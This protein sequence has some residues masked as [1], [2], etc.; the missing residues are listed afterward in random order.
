MTSP[1]PSPPLSLLTLPIEIQA[2][3]LTNRHFYALIP[4]PTHAELLSTET[5]ANRLLACVG[6][7]R[8]RPVAAFSPKMTM[9]KKAP[10]GAHAHNRFC[11]ECGRR[12]VP[13]P[14]RYVIGWRWKE[15]GAYFVRCLR[16]EV[17]GRAAEDYRVPFCFSCHT[18]DLERERAAR[19]LERVR[20]E[21]R[22]REERKVLREKRRRDWV[23]SGRALSDFSSADPRE[24]DDSE[25][26]PYNWGQDDDISYTGHS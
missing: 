21:A 16:C 24:E 12:P 17:I 19:E 2:A 1:S 11:I 7:T 13:G 18:Q 22:E 20:R 14:H 5:L 26:D 3:I 25:E 10:G 6:C 23:A 4:P 8:L 15:N 9:K